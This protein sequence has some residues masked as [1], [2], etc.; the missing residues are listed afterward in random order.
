MRKFESLV[1]HR[2]LTSNPIALATPGT[3]V[4]S[5]TQC[6]RLCPDRF[7]HRAVVDVKV[8]STSNGMQRVVSAGLDGKLRLFSLHE[9]DLLD[10]VTVVPEEVRFCECFKLF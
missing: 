1:T 5:S 7:F 10:E 6:K 9:G 8:V 3:E 2:H 4:G